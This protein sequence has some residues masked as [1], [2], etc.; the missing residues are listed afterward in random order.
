M[1]LC[2]ALELE[3]IC[4]DLF[5]TSHRNPFVHSVLTAET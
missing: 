2:D 1:N 4:L 5:K 3:Y